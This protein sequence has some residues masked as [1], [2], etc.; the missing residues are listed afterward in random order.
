MLI[1][2]IV[3]LA[4]LAT[5]LRLF[6]YQGCGARYRFWVS[7]FAYFL[8]LGSAW[9]VVDIAMYGHPASIPQ[10]ITSLS[11]FLLVWRAKGNAAGLARRKI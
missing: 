6:C 10:A 5:W 9:Q 7:L 1:S 2:T 11:L 3:V 4:N 8:M